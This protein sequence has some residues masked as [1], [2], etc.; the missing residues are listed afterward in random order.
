[1]LSNIGGSKKLVDY[2]IRLPHPSVIVMGDIL[3]RHNVK[4]MSHL[5]GKHVKKMVLTDMEAME[6]ALEAGTFCDR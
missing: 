2:L 5:K 4:A 3:N 6:T 1:M